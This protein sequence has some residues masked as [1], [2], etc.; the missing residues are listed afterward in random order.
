MYNPN[1]HKRKSIRLKEY[2]YSQEGYYFI[3]ICTQGRR[4]MLSEIK[5]ENCRNGF[6]ARPKITLYKFG[7]IIKDEIE[8]INEKYENIKINEYIIMPNHIHMII[9]IRAGTR[10]AP[11][12]NDIIRN[13]K[14]MTTLRYIKNIK[15]NFEKRVWQ[16]NYYEHIIRN[17][18]ELYATIEYIKYNPINW[19]NDP[20]N[21]MS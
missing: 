19:D 17:E 11:T 6:Y 16:R 8:K 1:I 20:L 14:S 10:P 5:N 7:K 21:K 2:D 3:T 18:K 12:L 9:E 4:K 15:K 13:F